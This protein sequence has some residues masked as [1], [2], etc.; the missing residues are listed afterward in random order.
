MQAA[1]LPSELIDQFLQD[2]V[3]KIPQIITSEE[4]AGYRQATMRI[5][6]DDASTEEWQLRPSFPSEGQ[7]LA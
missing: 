5:L 6:E 3:V 2:G 1:D 4:A 7:C